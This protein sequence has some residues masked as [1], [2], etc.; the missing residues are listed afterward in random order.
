MAATTGIV[1]AV[2]GVTLANEVLFAPLLGESVAV[3]WKIVPA[4]LGLALALGGL[5]RIAPD[6]AVGLA[7]L[8]LIT[9]IAVP[10]GNAPTPLDNINKVFGY[11]NKAAGFT[12]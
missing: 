3:N 2:G 4:T 1:L 7:W 10:L 6:F 11:G 5:E 8:A 9:A 12:K